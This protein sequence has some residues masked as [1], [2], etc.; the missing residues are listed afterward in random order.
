MDLDCQVKAMVQ[1]VNFLHR[2]PSLLRLAVLPL[3]FLWLSQDLL[4]PDPGPPGSLLQEMLVH[5]L[6][7]FLPR[8]VQYFLQ[9]G[10]I[11]MILPVPFQV[12]RSLPAVWCLEQLELFHLPEVQCFRQ[13][14][15]DFLVEPK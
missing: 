8:A 6:L 7:E 14:A 11:P 10:W 9:K 3:A 2:T 1:P 12:L 4:A 5:L 13:Q 15:P